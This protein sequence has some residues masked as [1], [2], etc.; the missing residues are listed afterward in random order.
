MASCDLDSSVPDWVIEYP[1]TLELFQNLGIDYCCGGKSLA[2][3]CREAGLD[4][5]AVLANLIHRVVQLQLTPNEDR[6]MSIPH[7]NPGEMIDVRPL[8]P[9]L[10]TARTSTLLKTGRVEVIR[11]VLP[12]GKELAEHKAPGEITVHCL[13]GRIAF[14]ARG[15]TEDLTAGQMLYLTAGEQHA[16]KCLEDA[17]ILLT[18]LFAA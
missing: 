18:I 3:A 9:A 6:T 2:Y 11:L 5:S 4:A 7:A 10:A 1:E 13:E 12:A 14:T 15:K 16:I 17:S 8:G